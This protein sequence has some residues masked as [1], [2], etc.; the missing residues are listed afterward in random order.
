MKKKFLALLLA[1]LM[2]VSLLP[3]VAFAAWEGEGNGSAATPWLIGKNTPS[4]V[5][6][7]LSEDG[8]TLTFSGTGAMQ[9]FETNNA[10]WAPCRDNITAAVIHPGVTS[11]G[12]KTFSGFS[13]AYLTVKAENPP[14]INVSSFN[15]GALEA[16]YVPYGTVETYKTADD[17]IDFGNY[18]KPAYTVSVAAAT[19]GTVTVDKDWFPL[20]T[21][22]EASAATGTVTV[23]ATPAEGYALTSL[24]YNDG[25]D[26]DITEAKSFTMPTANVTVTAVFKEIPTLTVTSAIKE[27]DGVP[28]GTIR[29]SS[30]ETT[31]A[32]YACYK[33]KELEEILTYYPTYET[34][35]AGAITVQ[36]SEDNG[37]TWEEPE[38]E[39][40]TKYKDP[41]DVL[42]RLLIEETDDYAAVTSETQRIW[43]KPRQVTVT[44]P[45]GLEYDLDKTD[46]EIDDDITSK[47]TV[48]NVLAGEEDDIFVYWKRD[49]KLGEREG[50]KDYEITFVDDCGD[51]ID[52]PVEQIKYVVTYQNGG[53]KFTGAEKS[54]TLTATPYDGDY[55]GEEH[56]IEIEGAYGKIGGISYSVEDDAGKTITPD[57]VY[58]RVKGT[59]D[60][61]LVNSFTPY[62][63]KCDLTL[64][65]KAEKEGYADA[66]A[67]V[68]F[69]I[70]PR[71][72]VFHAKDGEKE[73]DATPLTQPEY[74]EDTSAEEAAYKEKWGTDE[75]PY[76]S[77][78]F[79]AGEGFESEL[80]MTPESTITDVGEE[81][82]VIDQSPDKTALN[83]D[84]NPDNY[85]ISYLNGTL[86]V[87]HTHETDTH[88]DA[89]DATCEEYGT[90]EYWD[91]TGCDKKLDQ[92][93]KE[94][95]DIT[96]PTKP[97]TGHNFTGDAVSNNNG[98]HSFKCVNGTCEAVGTMD[99]QTAIKNGTETCT[100]DGEYVIGTGEHAGE[101]G[102]K[103]VCGDVG[104]YTAHTFDGEYVIGE[105]ENEGKHAQKCICGEIGEYVAHDFTSGDCVC[106]AKAKGVCEYTE[107]VKFTEGT[108]G[109]KL[110]GKDMG[111]FKFEA[112]DGG[113]K[114]MKTA[115]PG[116]LGTIL[117]PYLAMKD[118]KLTYT[119]SDNATIW[120]YKNGAFSASVKATQKSSGYWFGFI[121][122]PGRGS[123]TVTTTYYLST[124]TENAKLSTCC[125]CAE[126]YK[127]VT[128]GEHDYKYVNKCNGTHDKICK[129]CGEKT[130]ES[131]VYNPDT[132]KCVCGAYDPHEADVKISVDVKT[133]NTKQYSGFLFWGTWKN[134]T[135]YTATIKTE[136]TGVKVT[137]VQYQLNGGKWMTGTSVSSDKPIETL[138]VKAWDSNGNVHE[139]TYTKGN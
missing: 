67:E 54:L 106:G 138:K 22:T 60:W 95:E 18:I 34:N 4:D 29:K 105:G 92:D 59:E 48:E 94:I 55:D 25:T 50:N 117:N 104:N 17:W 6:A 40:P 111:W 123:K 10:P 37:D 2:V 73:F 85:I 131:C 118:G 31:A 30:V 88:H 132:H 45:T 66:T 96:D 134:V 128:S 71:I 41:V 124:V 116:L 42:Y 100:F 23:T 90:V 97:A 68:A 36:Y 78:G 27:Y 35:S 49:G 15:D 24:K 9:D 112:V 47:I 28:I 3:T 82:N 21:Y 57:N 76:D 93:A 70:K 62:K 64:E 119:D 86:K 5:T 133:K 58:I 14:N 63:D 129:N 135:T 39:N 80:V 44:A 130:N 77:T 103:C 53:F 72:V 126:L 46:E 121:Y 107:T 109:M 98:T 16:I 20:D 26:H 56:L 84:T 61:T 7:V 69:K 33:D 120:T 113:W 74:Y 101:H 11:L 99:G 127:T 19:H 51:A 91:C 87:T 52:D 102:Q 89:V 65:L 8:T 125:T 114:I 79:V 75:V 13:I 139:Y 122:I 110:G 83:S 32:S 81:T 12:A 38:A 1:A 108:F 43:I 136:A 137:K 115:K